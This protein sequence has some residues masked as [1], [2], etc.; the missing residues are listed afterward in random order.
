MIPPASCVAQQ[1]VSAFDMAVQVGNFSFF[2]KKLAD[3]CG[4]LAQS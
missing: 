2:H 4:A 3:T 1:G